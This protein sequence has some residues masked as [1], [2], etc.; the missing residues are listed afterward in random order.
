MHWSLYLLFGFPVTALAAYGQWLGA[1]TL[2]HDRHISALQAGSKLRLDM[3]REDRRAIYRLGE[4]I[5]GLSSAVA[6][7]GAQMEMLIDGRA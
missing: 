5:D 1:R 2:S 7:L 6:A 3:R 4:K